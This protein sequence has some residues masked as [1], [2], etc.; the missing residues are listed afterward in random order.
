MRRREFIAVVG[1]TTLT[2]PIVAH[3]QQ[4]LRRIGI[5]FGT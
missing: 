3:A 2:R 5:P 1:G 4:S